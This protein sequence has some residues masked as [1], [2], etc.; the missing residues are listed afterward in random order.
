LPSSQSARSGRTVRKGLGSRCLT[1]FNAKRSPACESARMRTLPHDPGN[2]YRQCGAGGIVVLSAKAP[3]ATSALLFNRCVIRPDGGDTAPS[4]PWLIRTASWLFRLPNG[5]SKSVTGDST[6]TAPCSPTAPIRRK[7]PD[8]LLGLE[9][10]C[11]Q[12]IRE[13]VSRTLHALSQLGKTFRSPSPPG[14]T[15]TNQPSQFS[16]PTAFSNGRCSSP[17]TRRARQNAAGEQPAGVYARL[18]KPQPQGGE[19]K[20]SNDQTQIAMN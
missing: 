2:A 17:G 1:S 19:S 5:K 18:P 3:S 10:K 13:S 11:P 16:I 7:S 15:P 20:R 8:N 14:S 12:Q 4:R 9:K 6:L